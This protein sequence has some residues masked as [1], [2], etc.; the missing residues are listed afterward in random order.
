M[1]AN[2]RPIQKSRAHLLDLF[3]PTFDYKTDIYPEDLSPILISPDQKVEWRAARF[4]LVP[5]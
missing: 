1:C 2:Y 5:F 4:G 3:E